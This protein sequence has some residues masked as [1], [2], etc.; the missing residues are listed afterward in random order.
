M[1]IETRDRPIINR[2]VP[3]LAI[4]RFIL[5]NKCFAECARSHIL[6]LA[7]RM[8]EVGLMVESNFGSNPFDRERGVDHQQLGLLDAV[9][10]QV[11]QRRAA[12]R[13]LHASGDIDWMKVELLLQNFI[14]KG[15]TVIR[16]Q[17]DGDPLGELMGARLQEDVVIPG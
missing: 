9:P 15:R 17:E 7:K 11:F 2:A 14:R 8:G 10:G 12:K 13:F 5:P 16:A 3:Y 6:Q 4:I 1:L